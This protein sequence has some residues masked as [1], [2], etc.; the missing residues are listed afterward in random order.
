LLIG[1]DSEI[2]AGYSARLMEGQ[3]PYL[4]FALEYP[5][6]SLLPFTLPRLLGPNPA[7]SDEEYKLR[8]V[9]V[10]L[11]LTLALGGNAL[12]TR[13]YLSG[14]AGSARPLLT[15]A[16]GTALLTPVMLWRYDVAPALCTSLALLAFLMGRTTW[17]GAWLGLGVAAKLYPAVLGP[18]FCAERLA[19]GDAKGIAGLVV[20]GLAALAL[21]VLPFAVLAPFGLI[22]FWRYHAERGIQVESLAGGAILLGARLGWAEASIA[23]AHAAEEIVSSWASAVHPFLPLATIVGT[24]LLS[25]LAYGRFREDHGGGRDTGATLVAYTTLVLLLFMTTSKVL[26]PQYLV[27]LLPL[28]PLLAVRHAALL[29][30]ACG[31]TAALFPWQYWALVRLEWPAVLLLNGRNFLLVVAMLALLREHLPNLSPPA[32][33]VRQPS[34]RA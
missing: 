4:D 31:L 22:G 5:P 20:G 24:L 12:R 30:G 29:L 9:L 23:P 10:M 13:W 34:I 27:W 2:Y 33:G 15:F 28:L 8:F 1:T 19:R 17:S 14:S 18:V 7:V 3:I 21:T 6:L 32:A 11:T 25:G 26:S 16:A